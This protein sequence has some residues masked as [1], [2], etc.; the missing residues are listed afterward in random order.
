[1]SSKPHT[2]LVV[3]DNPTTR[4]LY[5]AT[6]EAEGYRVLEAFDGR[7]GLEHLARERPALVRQDLVL[8]DGDG[9]ELARLARALPGCADLPIIAVS[10]FPRLLDRARAESGCFD[11]ALVKPVLSSVLLEVVGQ[12]LPSA[13]ATDDDF[14]RG[15]S[16]LIVD[17]DPVQLKLAGLRFSAVGFAV[18]TA[19]DAQSAIERAKAQPPDIVL[20]DVLMP[21]TDGYELSVA[22]RGL[23]ALAGVPIILLSAHYNGAYDEELARMAGASALVTRSATLR[24]TLEVVRTNLD[25]R[26]VPAQGLAFEQ[27]HA[28]HVIAQLKRQL[29]VNAGLSERSALQT[30]Q[31][32]VLASIAD[33]L[34]RSEDVEAALGDVLAACLDAGGIARGALF[35]VDSHDRLAL[36]LALGFPRDA[37]AAVEG[38]FGFPEL[39]ERMARGA[40]VVP[41]EQLSAHDAQTLL[42]RAGV[43]TAVVVPIMEGASRIG[44]LL[45]G[46]NLA[47]I[48]E[49]D[50]ATFGRSISAHIAQALALT[51]A[52]TRLRDSAEASRVLSSSLDMRETLASLGELAIKRLAQLCE[53]CMEG[54]PPMLHVAPT[55]P[56][57][58]R[59]A[60]AELRD[61]F[62]GQPLLSASSDPQAQED[63]RDLH[64][65]TLVGARLEL[66][67]RV[68]D[69]VF[70]M[71]TLAQPAGGRRFSEADVVVANDLVQRA[72]IAI[73]NARSYEAANAANRAKDEFLATVS[74][75]LRSPLTAMLGWAQLLKLGL[76][77]AR[78][79]A[80]VRAI[81]RNALAQAELIDDLLDMSRIA[82]GTMRLETSPFELGPIVEAAI[83][84]LR[85]EIQAG[86]VAVRYTA[87]A[88]G[89]LMADP[90]RVQQIVRNLLDNAVKFTPRGGHVEVGL[91]A[92]ASTVRLSVV[93]D[94][95]GIS[96]EF[97]PHV[98]DRFKQADGSSSRAHRGL[99]LGLAITRRLVEL[100]GG[101]IRAAS[102]G[103]GRGASFTVELPRSGQPAKTAGTSATTREA[104]AL[105]GLTVLVV[106]DEADVREVLVSLLE[107]SG[108][109]ATAA[110][111]ATE[112][113]AA[114]TRE[115]PDVLLSD[116]G[117]PG[118]DG[119]T[120]IRELRARPS[121]EGGSI[122]AIAVSGFA[123]VEDR[124]RALAAGFQTHLAKPVN[125][126]E[127]LATIT[128]LRRAN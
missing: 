113:L 125:T 23:P 38:L 100:H 63:E 26:G 55:L 24:E 82:S 128:S 58:T 3:E 32:A 111:S 65:V 84:S 105:D 52:F 5:R 18:T 106:D 102:E 117:M 19:T 66:P 75:E 89:T 6:L 54:M 4:K 10:G 90:K 30:A 72:A 92:T 61:R 22:L 17:D 42:A 39:L 11:A 77:E 20:C 120:L 107:Q 110:A 57:A 49:H 51:S 27:Q 36:S 64:R 62:P 123:G 119:Y 21:G 56:V 87:A 122:P 47:E 12:H 74:H 28:D 79:D 41:H 80:A 127:L 94:G 126:S 88:S 1:V 97:L 71:V 13:V 69:R 45:L 53:V 31:L 101:T 59:A 116:L 104:G 73:D 103:P 33:A 99:G 9:I 35:R 81:E 8:P 70:G 85:P 29:R 34:A 2:V 114:I 68:A 96:R 43:R 25:G 91:T 109:R 48:G 121:D 98:F 60:L 86:G 37:A 7:S 76:P 16:I 115:R 44:A 108:A 46:T 50:L 118:E 67:L 112:A 95:A 124:R 78:R 40:L 15:K 93:D 14:G 83:E